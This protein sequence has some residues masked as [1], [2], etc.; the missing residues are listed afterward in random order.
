MVNDPFKRVDKKLLTYVMLLAEARESL[1][2]NQRFLSNYV[3]AFDIQ[4]HIS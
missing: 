1:K 4:E 3:Q 2:V